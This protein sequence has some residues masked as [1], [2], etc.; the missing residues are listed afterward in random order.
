MAKYALCK[1]GP[2]CR[3]KQQSACGFAHR[4]SELSLPQQ[5]F[6]NRFVDESD[7][8]AGRAGIDVWFGQTYNLAQHSR[9]LLYIEHEEPPFPDWVRMYLW[10]YGKE[11]DYHSKYEDFGLMGRIRD[12]LLPR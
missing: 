5:V 8:R 12:D 6:P 11:K 9:I 1:H 4:I 7:V 2:H 3:R 10:F